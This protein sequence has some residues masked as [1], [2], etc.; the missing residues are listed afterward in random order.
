LQPLFGE[1]NQEEENGASIL[2]V[3]EPQPKKQRIGGLLEHFSE[4]I[5]QHSRANVGTSAQSKYFYSYLFNN[6]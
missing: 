4:S 3:E 6:Q 2:E 1:N 5:A